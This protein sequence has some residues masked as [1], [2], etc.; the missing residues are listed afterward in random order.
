MVLLRW[1][2]VGVGLAAVGL[3]GRV[4]VVAASIGMVWM[5]NGFGWLSVVA[6]YAMTALW[7]VL[8]A[9][10]WRGKAAA[11]A[12]WMIPLAVLEGAGSLGGLAAMVTGGLLGAPRFDLRSASAAA[13]AIGQVFFLLRT[14]RIS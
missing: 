9:L 10:L 7:P 14:A 8:L 5:L 6:F 3:I 4:V 12:R 1:P 11:L 13:F 2:R